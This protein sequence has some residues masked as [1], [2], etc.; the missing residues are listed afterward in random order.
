MIVPEI[1]G[2]RNSVKASHSF[3]ILKIKYMFLNLLLLFNNFRTLSEQIAF[4]DA[5]YYSRFSSFKQN[6]VQ[7]N[8]IAISH[9]YFIAILQYSEIIKK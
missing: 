8:C 2:Y 4:N 6:C 3:N 1:M 7:F 5:H 9:F